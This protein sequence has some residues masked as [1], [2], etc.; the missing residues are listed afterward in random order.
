[1]MA[2]R[3]RRSQ[4]AEDLTDEDT[5]EPSNE[6]NQELTNDDRGD[7]SATLGKA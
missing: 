5:Y 6:E 3:S 4:T 2:E 7:P 1:M